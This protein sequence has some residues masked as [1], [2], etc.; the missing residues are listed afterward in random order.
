MRNVPVGS[1]ALDLA[2]AIG[3]RLAKDAIAARVNGV[4]TDLDTE[5]SDG[6]RVAIVTPASEDGRDVLR[7]SSAHVMAQAVTRLLAWRALRHRP[8]NS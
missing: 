8:G 4:L 3:K 7:H 5:L 6:D 2:S 1:S